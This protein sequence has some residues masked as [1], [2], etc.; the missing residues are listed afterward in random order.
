MEEGQSL[1]VMASSRRRSRLHVVMV[2]NEKKNEDDEEG[3]LY[4]LY[5][6]VWYIYRCACMY[7][8]INLYKECYISYTRNITLI[9]GILYLLYKEYYMS[10]IYTDIHMV[11]AISPIQGMLCLL[12]KECNISPIYT[13]YMLY[14]L[15]KELIML[16]L[17]TQTMWFALIRCVVVYRRPQVLP[18]IHLLTKIGRFPQISTKTV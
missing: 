1:S 18:W 10:Y 4:L 17:L 8:S 7:K 2:E 13:R 9:Q 12:Y 11:Y 16:Y 5:R 15:Y 3:V 6:S 14:L